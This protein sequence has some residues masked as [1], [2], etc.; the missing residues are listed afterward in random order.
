MTPS[1]YSPHRPSAVPARRFHAAVPG[2]LAL[3]L[4]VVAQA[5][6]LA[7]DQAVVA[8]GGARS[9]SAGGCLAVTATLGQEPLTP[10]SGGGFT[11]APGLWSALA[12]ASGDA[13]FNDG[14]QECL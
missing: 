7:I 5:G 13:L 10:A 2:A 11:L 12:G 8:G 4:A 3:C 6:G 1:R 14:F 9:Q